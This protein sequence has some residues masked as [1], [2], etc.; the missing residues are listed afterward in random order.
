MVKSQEKKSA[1]LFSY[2]GVVKCCG[3]LNFEKDLLKRWILHLT[4]ERMM[5][6]D[7][8]YLRSTS[9]KILLWQY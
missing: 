1:K 5:G 4:K 3:N 8:E 7:E 6:F 9:N 2:D